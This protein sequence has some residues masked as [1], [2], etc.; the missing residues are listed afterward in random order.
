[1][2]G[3]LTIPKSSDILDPVEDEDKQKIRV[4]N[5][6]A[7]SDLIMSID[8]TTSAGKVAFSLV[9]GTKSAD[10]EDGNA[11]IAFA[12]LTN[13]YAPK[14]AAS[15]AKT[16]RLFYQA[17]LKKQVDPDI[18]ITYLEGLRTTMGDMESFITDKQFIM[19][20]MNN[21]NKD[22]D[23][24]VEN[25]E[26]LINDKNDP[27]TIEQMRE[28]LSLKHE[29]L[30][31]TDDAGEFESDDDGEHALY[32]GAGR[33]KGKCNKCGK[34]GHKAVDCRSNSSSNKGR[35]NNGG[36]GNGGKRFDGTCHYC[37]K[38]GHRASDYFK[39]KRD[40]GGEQANTAKGKTTGKEEVA[41]I[42]L[43]VI[44][45]EEVNYLMREPCTEVE[46]T[47]TIHYLE[48]TNAKNIACLT[49]EG[50][51]KYQVKGWCGKELC[52]TQVVDDDD[53]S[54]S[55]FDADDVSESSS[56]SSMPPLLVRKGKKWND[57]DESDDDSESSSGS[58]M[59]SLL[60]R[61]GKKW[62]D[63]DESDDDDT[64]YEDTP[65]QDIALVVDNSIGRA[66]TDNSIDEMI[67]YIRLVAI[68]KGIREPNVDS[69]AS[70]VEDK[71]SEID[72]KTPREVVANI[73]TINGSLQD[74]GRSMFHT[75]TLYV[76]ARVGVDIICP[77]DINQIATALTVFEI[78]SDSDDDSEDYGEVGFFDDWSSSEDWTEDC[79]ESDDDD[80]EENV[81]YCFMSQ[82]TSNYKLNANTWLGD[83]AA[84]T[85]MGFSD[86]GMTEVELINSPVRIGN[87]KAL[88]AT[89]IGKRRIAIIQ[90]D[91]SSQDAILE[92]YKCVPELWVNLFSISKS[93]QNGWNISNKGVEIKLSKG[94]ANIVFDRII[95]ASKGLVVGVEVVP[96]IDAMANMML[97]R[98]KT[99]DI[100]VLHSV[101][102]HPSQD[103]TKQT[104]QYY[105]WKIT[106]TFKPCSNCQTAKSKQNSVM[107]ESGKKSMIPGERLFIDTSSVKTKSFGGSK[108]WLLVVDDCTDVAWSAFLRKKSDQVDRIVELIKDLA[109]K[110]KTTVKYIRCD[111]AGENGSLERECAKQ[112]LGIQFEYTGPGT[113][114]FN[115]RVERKFAP[116]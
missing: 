104:A 40:Q 41:D 99:I 96:R 23:N 92:E 1:L 7:Y 94:Q 83:S 59:P 63:P 111:N 84:S 2:L 60:V 16:N 44:D 30:Y 95:K 69:W 81:E 102:G 46:V 49:C 50:C 35:T 38:T 8:T 66:M 15:L 62:K 65:D 110:H 26:K 73:I 90:K 33:W 107:K 39:K 114:Q 22:Y 85:H 64:S 105:G 98:G 112:G 71:L 36:G 80:Y 113:P 79:E 68:K 27:L 17:K 87:G 43:T 58:S 11:E 82:T 21:L 13:K 4:L 18:F 52:S 48:N 72:M 14:T 32:A 75:K 56:G 103:I 10:Y 28:D 116:C 24:T 89:K 61:K 47:E 45:E 93:L 100:N 54:G 109:T 86:E 25:L 97:D 55:S 108:F 78:P 106:G 70:S 9:R 57:P 74:H 51:K 67:D 88:T 20:V 37:Q 53:Y 29:R 42:V 5:E 115:G 91:G 101:L 3:K 31:G 12:R 76:L 19:H 6:D 34:Q 77:Q